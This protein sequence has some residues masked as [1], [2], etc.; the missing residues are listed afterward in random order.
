MGT[1]QHF[2]IPRTCEHATTEDLLLLKARLAAA[3]ARPK[4]GSMQGAGQH[5]NVPRTYEHATLEDLLLLKARLAAALARFS[6]GSMQG[7]A[8]HFNVR[9]KTDMAKIVIRDGLAYVVP[10]T[11]DH[12][13]SVNKLP[14]TTSFDWANETSKHLN[15][16]ETEA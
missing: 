13:E 1:D 16:R 8:E 15:L 3:L 2:N 5:F 9:T 14:A 12:T 11:C 4:G 6:V 7:T 10:C